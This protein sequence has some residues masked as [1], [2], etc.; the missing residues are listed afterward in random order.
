MRTETKSKLSYTNT[1]REHTD[2]KGV[3]RVIFERDGCG[4]V[5]VKSKTT[6]KFRYR[7]IIGYQKQRG[8]E[9]EVSFNGPQVINNNVNVNSKSNSNAAIVKKIN[10]FETFLKDTPVG[11]EIKFTYGPQKPKKPKKGQS[12]DDMYVSFNMTKSKITSA[13]ISN[14]NR[15]DKNFTQHTDIQVFT[16]VYKS[17]AFK[18]GQ[19]DLLTYMKK[20]KHLTNN[21]N[22]VL[23]KY[24]DEIH[25]P[26]SIFEKPIEYLS[27]VTRRDFIIPELVEDNN[28]VKYVD[29]HSYSPDIYVDKSSGIWYTLDHMYMEVSLLSW[30]TIIPSVP[31]YT[32][33]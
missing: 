28:N 5:R 22:D 18:I 24:P 3:T 14:S 2:S 23:R 21:I 1:S 31:Q 6:G 20:I 25:K 4:Y 29:F 16:P 26:R 32:R 15:N 7:K 13:L 9:E 30:E 33:E 17:V 19:D 27:R 12:G 11:T 10:D 8:G